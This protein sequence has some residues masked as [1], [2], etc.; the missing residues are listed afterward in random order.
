MRPSHC[1]LAILIVAIWGF[2]FVVI[3]LGLKEVA[4]LALCC[5]R[6]FLASI[7]AVFLVKK[8]AVPYKIIASYGLIMFALQFSLLFLGMHAGVTAGLA[9]L[10]LQVQVFFTILFA[11]LFLNEKPNSWQIIGALVSFTGIA[12]VG[13]KLNNSHYS[14]L[15][16]LLLVTASAFWGAGNLIS[17]KAGKINMFAFV[18][19]GSLFAWPPLLVI[20]FLV[21][22]GS[23]IFV[24]L[25]HLSWVSLFSILYIVYPTTLFGFGAWNWLLK[26][27]QVTIIAPFT[28][29]VPVFGMLSSFLVLGE[30]LQ[31]WK[32]VA[33]VLVIVGL[34]INL[35]MPRFVGAKG[36]SRA[37]VPL[38][39]TADRPPGA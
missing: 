15:G 35:L 30:P 7:P 14:L 39:K 29:L 38:Q 25:H 9:S 36:V 26:K 17:K 27:Y 4:P 8:P 2:N 11:V 1:L 21:E 28:L 18:I 31:L 19:W 12:I 20:A 5:A 34:C 33:A 13:L 16:F 10:V 22:G 6:F 37:A 32:I 23:K 3:Q 24:N